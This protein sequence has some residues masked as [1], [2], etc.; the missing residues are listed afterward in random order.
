MSLRSLSSGRSLRRSLLRSIGCCRFS[1][2]VTSGR[3]L[4]FAS[5]SCVTKRPLDRACCCDLSTGPIRKQPLVR[6]SARVASPGSAPSR[7]PESYSLTIS[8]SLLCLISGHRLP[9]AMKPFRSIVSARRH[10]RH[11]C[12]ALP[13]A[14][15]GIFACSV[16]HQGKETMAHDCFAGSRH[17]NGHRRCPAIDDRNSRA[18]KT[19]VRR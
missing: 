10:L 18:K 7:I 4:A 3:L 2:S 17:R 1:V 9:Q 14:L 19:M 12:V 15:W 16:G 5:L 8:A 13:T 11:R 6:F